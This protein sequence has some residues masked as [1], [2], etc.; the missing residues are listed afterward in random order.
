MP[1]ATLGQSPACGVC[2][3][4]AVKIIASSALRLK[5][6]GAH[7][8]S[9]RRASVSPSSPT[10]SPIGWSGNGFPLVLKSAY[11]FSRETSTY[12]RS[13]ELSKT[14]RGV[15]LFYWSA[16]QEQPFL[17][18]FPLFRVPPELLSRPPALHQRGGVL[19]VKFA[20]WPPPIC[21]VCDRWH[22]ST[23][24]SRRASLY[25]RRVSPSDG[26]SLD[27]HRVVHACMPAHAMYVF[28]E[29]WGWRH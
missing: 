26:L 7:E 11:P 21:Y 12:D 19:C 29:Y 10:V 6:G 22:F 28:S 20:S 2:C 24:S 27:L 8:E 3:N 14:L 16:D 25:S 23:I 9:R 17:Q 5:L 18:P 4:H 1:L 15:S 13:V